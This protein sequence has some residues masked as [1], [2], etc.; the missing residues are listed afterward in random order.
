[1]PLLFAPVLLTDA[2]LL[3]PHMARAAV[4]LSWHRLGGL[5]V[6][7]GSTN[8]HKSRSETSLVAASRCQ[9]TS[10][11]DVLTP[12]GSHSSVCSEI[13]QASQAAAGF[14]RVWPHRNQNGRRRT[15]GA[16]SYLLSAARRHKRTLVDQYTLRASSDPSHLKRRHHV[17]WNWTPVGRCCGSAVEFRF[18][19]LDQ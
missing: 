10:L 8:S 2:T 4:S 3:A 12:A 16:R 13:A 17:R 19:R 1:M 18:C 5:W 14:A 11:S 7:T 9:C 15:S 6:C